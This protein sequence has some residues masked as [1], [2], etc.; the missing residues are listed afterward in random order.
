MSQFWSQT[1]DLILNKTVL[2]STLTVQFISY[3][4]TLFKT[5]FY[6]WLILDS[7]GLCV[8]WICCSVFRLFLDR[9][10]VH[11]DGCLSS[12]VV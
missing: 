7:F 1:H 8:Q 3:H 4:L 11:A 10:L 5:I 2:S 6:R 12:V 9:F